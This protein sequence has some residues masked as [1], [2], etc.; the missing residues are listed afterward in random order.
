MKIYF[1]VIYYDTSLRPPSLLS[2]AKKV[3]WLAGSTALKCLTAG[4][5]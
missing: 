3:N 1:R 5:S 4:S 2:W